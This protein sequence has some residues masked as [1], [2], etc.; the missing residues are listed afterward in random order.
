MLIFFWSNILNFSIFAG[1]QKTYIFIWVRVFGEGGGHL[2]F[3]YFMGFIST[4]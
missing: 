4:K 2:K 1:F 3:D